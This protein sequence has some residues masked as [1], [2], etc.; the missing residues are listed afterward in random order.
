MSC[1]RGRRESHTTREILTACPELKGT[2]IVLQDLP[3]VLEHENSLQV[4]LTQVR[5]QPYNFCMTYNQCVVSY[6]VFASRPPLPHSI[7]NHPI[8]STPM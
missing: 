5:A 4:D 8:T 7:V 3:A 6:G 1:R 2:T